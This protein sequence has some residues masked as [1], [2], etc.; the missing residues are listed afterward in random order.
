MLPKERVQI[1]LNGE[2]PDRV[3]VM[4]ECDFDYIA[5]AAGR[6]PW[7]WV[8]ADSLE[9]A[10]IHEACFLRHP[11]DLWPVWGGP[12]R[13]A[14]QHRRII[15]EGDMAFYE[16]TRTGRR[17]RIAW[18][19]DLLDEHGTPIELDSAGNPV[20]PGRWLA[21]RGYARPVECESDIVELM[22]PVPAL[23]HWTESG[24]FSNLVYLLPRY[25]KHFYLAFPLNTIFADALDLFGGFEEGL[26]ALYTKPMLFHRV[27]ETI[28]EW[29]KSRLRAGVALGAPGTWMIEYM[30]GADTISP[31]TYEE[32]VLPYQQEIAREAHRLGC[33]VYLWYLGHVMPLVPHIARLEIDGLFPEQGRKGYE[34]DIVALR[35]GLG[36]RL[37]LIG[38]NNERDLIEGNRQ[39][40]ASEIARQ[41]KGAGSS[42][43]FIVGTTILTA[44]VSP[45]HVDFYLDTAHRLGQ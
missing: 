40:L 36:D 13:A 38:F 15:R 17:F 12:S 31:R 16:D 7:E 29:K 24:F 11:R 42:G 43:A 6:A 2:R 18:N 9:Q 5:K 39:R 35:R 22:G 1:A 4:L 44:E 8:Q 37:C 41:I 32:F 25:G 3:P 21:S 28:V 26:I 45:D 33:Q 30:A 14:L 19:G 34:V 23:D 27:L 10:R 20:A